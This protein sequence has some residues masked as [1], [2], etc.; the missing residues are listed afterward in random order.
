MDGDAGPQVAAV[1]HESYPYN[2]N[3]GSSR[4]PYY[5]FQFLSNNTGFHETTIHDISSTTKKKQRNQSLQD[6]YLRNY[7]HTV[8]EARASTDLYTAQSTSVMRGA[9]EGFSF[10]KHSARTKMENRSGRSR[11]ESEELSGR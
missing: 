11:I 4:L 3:L 10:M 8:D 2:S 1:H 6:H 7:N 5:Q 9:W